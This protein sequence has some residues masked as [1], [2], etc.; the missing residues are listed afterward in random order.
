MAGE[1]ARRLG[2]INSWYLKFFLNQFFKILVMLKP[3]ILYKYYC[4]GMLLTG[5]MYK[6]SKY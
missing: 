4:I 1:G 5:K 3:M 6:L 2:V